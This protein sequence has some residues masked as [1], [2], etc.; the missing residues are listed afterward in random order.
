MRNLNPGS[1]VKIQPL[2]L[3]S[4]IHKKRI[5]GIDARIERKDG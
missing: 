3:N 4:G 5:A 1:A 2:P